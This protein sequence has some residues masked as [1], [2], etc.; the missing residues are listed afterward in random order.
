MGRF[1]ARLLI[2]ALRAETVQTASVEVTRYLSRR[3]T[4]FILRKLRAGSSTFQ[5]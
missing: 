4:A 2:A 5:D 1:V 3:A